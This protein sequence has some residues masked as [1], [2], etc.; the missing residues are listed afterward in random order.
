MPQSKIERRRQGQVASSGNLITKSNADSGLLVRITGRGNSDN[1]R[2][3]VNLTTAAN[4]IT[5]VVGVLLED[6]GSDQGVVYGIQGQFWIQTTSTLAAGLIGQEILP[7]ASNS[8]A[9]NGKCAA[10]ATG[11]DGTKVLGYKTESSID[12]LLVELNLPA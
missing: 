10:N 5:S 11:I 12:Y 9:D 4:Q 8:G 1:M 7:V 6:H 2:P 3:Q